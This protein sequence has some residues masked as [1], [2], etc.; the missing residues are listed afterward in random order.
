MK[1]YVPEADDE[2]LRTF[3]DNVL[4]IKCVNY[5]PYHEEIE[6]VLPLDD[7]ETDLY[8]WYMELR[9]TGSFEE[10]RTK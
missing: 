9:C 8:K 3:I 10:R 7:W 5:R 2:S 1:Q 4:N 6:S